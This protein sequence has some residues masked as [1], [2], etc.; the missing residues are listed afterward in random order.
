[1]PRP[2]SGAARASPVYFDPV[3]LVLADRGKYI[4]AAQTLPGLLS[5]RTAEQAPRLASFEGWSDTARSAL[6][7][8]GK[9]DPVDSMET[10]REED[11]ERI[12]L[13]EMMQAWERVIGRGSQTRATLSNVI[14]RGTATVKDSLTGQW[15][16]KH[17]DL[18]AAL[19]GVAFR[20]TGKRAKARLP[21]ARILAATVQ[22]PNC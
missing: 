13:I 15:E 21:D 2:W 3:A 8:L 11:P 19:E 22:G 17:P 16:P 14:L 4:A 20:A 9:A 7:W 1:M 12:E 5:C 6:I 10:A 18:Y